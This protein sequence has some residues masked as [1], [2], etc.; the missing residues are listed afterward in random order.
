MLGV[1]EMFVRHDRL[2]KKMIIAIR[3]RLFTPVSARTDFL[4]LPGIPY[5]EAMARRIGLEPHSRW[6][7]LPVQRW[8]ELISVSMLFTNV[9]RW[10][11]APVKPYATPV[12]HHETLDTLRP[13]GSIYWSKVHQDFFTQARS[14]KLALEFAKENFSSPPKIDPV[15]LHTL[16]RLFGYLKEKGVEL[17]FVHPPFNPIYFDAV[18]GSPYRDGL[19]KIEAITQDY[20]KKYDAKVFGSFDPAEVGCTSKMFIDAEHSNPECLGKLF[21]QFA[22]IAKLGEEPLSD[23]F[24]TREFEPEPEP[25]VISEVDAPKVAIAARPMAV[26]TAGKATSDDPNQIETEARQVPVQKMDRVAEAAAQPPLP[27]L[28][29]RDLPPL[30]TPTLRIADVACVAPGIRIGQMQEIRKSEGFGRGLTRVKR[31]E[32]VERFQ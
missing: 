17:Y 20:A 24:A 23:R 18:R 5:Y 1:V 29:R 22:E 2:P 13:G 12:D 27:V 3:D 16:D 8:R 7:T 14:D 30:P 28:Y 9:S 11:K 26:P 21:K 32:L 4:W 31:G 10:Y 15:G 25:A 6:E 19:R